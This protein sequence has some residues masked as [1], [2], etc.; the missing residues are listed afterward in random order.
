MP[1]Q[2]RMIDRDEA[3]AVAPRRQ[4]TTTSRPATTTTPVQPTAGNPLLGLLR[5]VT[6]IANAFIQR[7]TGGQGAIAAIARDVTGIVNRFTTQTNT[8]TPGANANLPQTTTP[9]VLR[10]EP[11]EIWDV[12]NRTNG[13]QTNLRRDVGTG[14][15]TYLRPVGQG[16]HLLVEPDA[17]QIRH[18]TT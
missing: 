2:R 1:I 5:G 7:A 13:Q 12:R 3:R 17:V 9:A 14:G 10:G 4:L 6:N 15:T 16:L 8:N 18:D 11:E